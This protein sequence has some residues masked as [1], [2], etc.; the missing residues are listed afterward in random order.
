M[1]TTRNRYSLEQCE[2]FI[3]RNNLQIT[4]QELLNGIHTAHANL[5]AL[6]LDRG[7]LRIEEKDEATLISAAET[8]LKFLE[9]V[10][11]EY[12]TQRLLSE[13]LGI[14]YGYHKRNQK[15]AQEFFVEF[16][17]QVRMD[18][19]DDARAFI[20]LA[21]A[22]SIQGSYHETSLLFSAQRIL[23]T[24]LENSPSATD[25]TAIEVE[26][27]YIHCFLG[28]FNYRKSFLLAENEPTRK[29]EYLA[30][31]IEFMQIAIGIQEKVLA[32]VSDDLNKQVTI[33]L[34]NSFHITGIIHDKAGNVEKGLQ[35]YQQAMQTEAQYE[36]AIG[37]RHFLS[38]VTN[39]NYA[40]SLTLNFGRA[41]DALT[42]LDETLA[43][44]KEYYKNP[45]TGQFTD[46][47][48]IAK[49]YH[50][51]GEALA[52]LDSHVL[53]LASFQQS[54][55]M[56]MRLGS[57]KIAFDVLDTQKCLLS[58][59]TA[60]WQLSNGDE[61][62]IIA[63]AV[64]SITFFDW[65]NFHT[66]KPF[67]SLL[68]LLQPLASNLVTLL[69]EKEMEL[70]AVPENREQVKTMM[71]SLVPVCYQL[72]TLG[73]H[74][75]NSFAF[76][77]FYLDTARDFGNSE[78]LQGLWVFNHIGLL[79]LQRLTQSYA[80]TDAELH[81]EFDEY[82]EIF[83]VKDVEDVE[84]ISIDDIR[85]TYYVDAVSSANQVLNHLPDD[86]LNR[87]K[88][89]AFANSVIASADYEI[90]ARIIGS[91]QFVVLQKV[92]QRTANILKRH[93]EIND[94]GEQYVQVKNNYATLIMTF[95]THLIWADSILSDEIRKFA[96]TLPTPLSIYQSIDTLRKQQ[97]IDK[98]FPMGS[99]FYYAYAGC[100]L[101]SVLEVQSSEGAPISSEEFA[102]LQL[103]LENCTQAISILSQPNSVYTAIAQDAIKLQGNI[104]QA[105]QKYQ[106]QQ[107]NA[108]TLTLGNS[109]PGAAGLFSSSASAAQ[110][111][112]TQLAA[113][114]QE[115]K[116]TSSFSL[117]SGNG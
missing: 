112:A 117:S 40:R 33:E 94:L 72:G 42:L 64:S 19:L 51:R 4:G 27:G 82:L 62:S 74:F 20:Y 101:Q 47:F 38:F 80:K 84:E 111:A 85:K 108:N 13:K 10:P 12:S 104:T 55:D 78:G 18:T 79:C 71:S 49:T 106:A 54:F 35:A 102:T 75:S 9:S 1:S 29:A 65:E 61:L 53:A 87:G 14:Y 45:G 25:V 98:Q 77:Q 90:E 93:E 2:E 83:N 115:Q 114:N 31:A 113:V 100:L 95:K 109:S 23:A 69:R 76:A 116:P 11:T 99:G 3:Q 28:L 67:Q 30:E 92:L 66:I 39:Q 24:L 110:T 5:D 22:G 48:D 15:K 60:V 43:G 44:Q 6:N 16:K 89:E 88:L 57:S 81:A 63:Q 103:S 58:S 7:T 8:S 68:P 91:D 36:E 46:N 107:S 97:K 96:T 59:A 17:K 21:Y 34:A 26:Q 41:S 73:V 32:S 56:K 52:K 37:R 50:F 105:I 86:A 70:D